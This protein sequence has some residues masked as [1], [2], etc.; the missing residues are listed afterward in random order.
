MK[1]FTG[2]V[3]E[4][5]RSWKLNPVAYTGNVPPEGGDE[6]QSPKRRVLSIRQDER[7]C[8]ELC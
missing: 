2:Y 3:G 5:Q 8:P 6:I 1:K 4:K 7:Y